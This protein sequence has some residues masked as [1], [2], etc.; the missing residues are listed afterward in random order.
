MSHILTHKDKVAVLGDVHGGEFT[1]NS[2]IR[3]T[4]P[5]IDLLVQ[6]GDFMCYTSKQLKSIT[7]TANKYGVTVVFIPGN[8]EDWPLLTRTT[9]S[10]DIVPLTERVWYAPKGATGVIGNID[11]LFAGG[12]YSVD[13]WA[14]ERFPEE[15]ISPDECEYMTRLGEFPFVFSHDCP[16]STPMP[17]GCFGLKGALNAQVEAESEAHRQTLD[18]I[19][20]S[21]NAK[22]VVHGHYHYAYTAEGP[23]GRAT[24]GLA[25]DGRS[26]SFGTVD[27]STLKYT[28]LEFNQSRAYT[29]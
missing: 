28:P 20:Q 5:D 13:R 23:F 26:G 4:P 24:V 7:Y 2:A 15:V 6:V 29:L 8:H 11:V 18:S 12:A 10:Y 9:D 25:C 14:G 16:S 21:V 19:V 22:L 27:V 1:V 3:S 17:E